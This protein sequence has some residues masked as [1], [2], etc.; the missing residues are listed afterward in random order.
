MVPQSL[1]TLLRL[2]GC[3]REGVLEEVISLLNICIT[4]RGYAGSF[5]AFLSY[6]FIVKLLMIQATSNQKVPVVYL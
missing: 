1:G 2:L 3:E 6:Y 5:L 4:Y